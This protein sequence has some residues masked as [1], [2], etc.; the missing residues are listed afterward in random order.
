LICF[1]T[2]RK[3]QTQS[4]WA[5]KRAAPANGCLVL[6]ANRSRGR[7]ANTT[8]WRRKRIHTCAPPER[9]RRAFCLLT[10]TYHGCRVT[11][12]V[13]TGNLLRCECVSLLAGQRELFASPPLYAVSNRGRALGSGHVIDAAFL[14]SSKKTRS[15][16]PDFPL[17][18][19]PL[20]NII[21]CTSILWRFDKL[22]SA[23]CADASNPDGA[24][25][26]FCNGRCC[27]FS[28]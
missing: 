14:A 13:R 18:L 1:E 12:K 16:S 7:E 19:F 10:K 9:V 5:A 8:R 27:F 21:V 3:T 20:P 26:Y 22:K 15:S 4:C 25:I 2:G 6:F 23:H 24:K 28:R 17:T 11:G